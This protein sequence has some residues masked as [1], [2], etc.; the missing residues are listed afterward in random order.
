MT[1]ISRWSSGTS[2]PS[3]PIDVPSWI[4]QGTQR[5][6]LRDKAQ[7][8]LCMAFP[9]P[10]R[11]DTRRHVAHLVA[12]IASGLGGRFFDE[13]R[14]KQSLA[15]TVHV[16]PSFRAAAG[17]MQAY[18]ATSPEKDDAARDGLLQQFR[19]LQEEPVTEEELA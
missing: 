9:G 1:L 14:E 13:L 18:I 17:M 2:S 8:A 11:S 10:A 3:V 4:G 5:V 12:V 16:S 19:R 15:Y 6:D 7:T